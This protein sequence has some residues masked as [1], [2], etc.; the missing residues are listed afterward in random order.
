MTT[1]QSRTT[2]ATA[3]LDEHGDSL[4]SCDTQLRQYGG[5]NAFSVAT[6]SSSSAN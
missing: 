5:I 6:E 2:P 3:D 1:D 4:Q